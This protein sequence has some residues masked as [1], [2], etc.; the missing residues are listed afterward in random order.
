VKKIGKP[1]PPQG[2]SR[3]LFRAPIY[4]YRAGLGWL[5]GGRFLLLHHVGRKSGQPRQAVVEVVRHD[6]DSDTYVIASGFGAKSQWFQN[7]IHQPEVTIQVGRRK[8]AVRAERLSAEEGEEE[9]RRY[10][11]VHATAAREL[12]RFMGYQVDGSEEDYRALGREI[13]FVAL[14]PRDT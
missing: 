7:L 14:R 2:L 13:P 1:Q 10:A 12:A 4:L 6:K 9:M 11:R 8:L 3:L 5:L